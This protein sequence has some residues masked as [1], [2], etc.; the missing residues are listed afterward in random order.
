[1]E[2]DSQEPRWLTHL[3]KHGVAVVKSVLSKDEVEHARQKFWEWLQLYSNKKQ[4]EMKVKHN[5]DIP[6]IEMFNQGSLNDDIWPINCSG[7]SRT[8]FVQH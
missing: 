3:N 7:L 8:F 2:S 6:G 1:M 5:I 4:Q